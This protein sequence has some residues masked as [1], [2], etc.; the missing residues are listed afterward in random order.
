MFA[1]RYKATVV[2]GT[3]RDMM[4]RGYSVESADLRESPPVVFDGVLQDGNENTATPT[5]NNIAVDYNLF[6]TIYTGNDEDW[7]EEN[8]HYLRMQELRLSYNL[9]AKWLEKTVILSQASVFVSGNDLFVAT[10]YSG[11]DA[12]G[13]T[14]SAAGGGTGGEGIDVW[15]LPSPRGYS[16]GINLT[17]K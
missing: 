15:A 10:N 13:N 12:V 4:L 14:M 16:I 5:P 3:K 1:G 7:I 17:F 8:V 2:N 6:S 11:I 9:P